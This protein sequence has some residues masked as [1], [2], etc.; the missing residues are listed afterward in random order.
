MSKQMRS[1][2][3]GQRW[4]AFHV[5][6]GF[7]K[8]RVWKALLIEL[9]CRASVRIISWFQLS[10]E[11][12]Y[13]VPCVGLVFGVPR[14]LLLLFSTDVISLTGLLLS[15]AVLVQSWIVRICQPWEPSPSWS[16][17]PIVEATGYAQAPNLHIATQLLP[18]G[19]ISFW[20]ALVHPVYSCRSYH[21][22]SV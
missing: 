19:G 22:S 4:P 15:L 20:Y 9:F 18:L 12:G 21:C 5:S 3:L 10:S 1:G 2:R 11:L 14:F 6:L 16:W 7:L 13:Q 17:L 8:C